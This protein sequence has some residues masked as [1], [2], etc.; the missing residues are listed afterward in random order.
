MP[1]KLQLVLVLSALLL[2]MCKTYDSS[3]PVA[4]PNG[5]SCNNYTNYGFLERRDEKLRYFIHEKGAECFYKC[6]DGTI[7]QPAL[8]EKFS[9]SS[10]LYTASQEETDARFCGVAAPPTPTLT[11]VSTSPPPTASALPTIEAS[12]TLELSP[13]AAQPLLTGD[14]PM[15]DLGANLMNLRIAQPAPDLTGKTL[16]VQISDKESTCSVNPVNKSLLSCT[17]PSGLIFPVHIVVSLDGVIVND[18][19]FDGKGCAQLTT[20]VPGSTASTAIP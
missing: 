2:T 8:V 6:P 13:T 5:L 10:S 17:I 20:P 16:K 14:V 1:R 15:C 11:P 7:S 4:S 9:S 3:G 18:F 19:N 12:P